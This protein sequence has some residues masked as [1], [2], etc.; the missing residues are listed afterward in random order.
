M[1]A[2]DVRLMRRRG[3]LGYLARL[4]AGEGGERSEPGEG[5]ATSVSRNFGRFLHAMRMMGF[6]R[7]LF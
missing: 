1:V 5:A 6:P 4:V 2:G 7:D 3:A